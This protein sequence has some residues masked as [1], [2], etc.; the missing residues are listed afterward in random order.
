MIFATSI[1][2]N[3]VI[4]YSA[5]FQWRLWRLNPYISPRGFAFLKRGDKIDGIRAGGEKK[6]REIL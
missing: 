6:K 4:V 5:A 2:R 1:A 3:P